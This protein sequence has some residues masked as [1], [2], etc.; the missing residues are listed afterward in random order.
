MKTQIYAAPAVKGLKEAIFPLDCTRMHHFI[1][2]CFSKFWGDIPVNTE[3]F[4]YN[5][6]KMLYKR[7]RRW[8][9][10]VQML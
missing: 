3:R 1:E 6:C 9:D 2:P 4:L 10:V 7:R 5:T 8:A